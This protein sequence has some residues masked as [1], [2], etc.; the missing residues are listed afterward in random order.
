MQKSEFLTQLRAGDPSHAIFSIYFFLAYIFIAGCL[1]K[2]G[3]EMGKKHS[4]WAW[5]PL[6]NLYYLCELVDAPTLYFIGIFI[7]PIT[8]LIVVAA[9]G[10]LSQE[11]GHQRWFG[12]LIVLPLPFWFFTPYILA[13]KNRNQKP[14][15]VEFPAPKKHKPE[16][17]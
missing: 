10:L 4:Y 1:Q 8:V 2:I 7:P 11:R 13:F 15:I 12:W 17:N 14:I 6:L 16:E 3:K 5:I 9:W